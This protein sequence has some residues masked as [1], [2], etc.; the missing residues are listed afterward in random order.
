[1]AGAVTPAEEAAK[2]RL[3][4]ESSRLAA[5]EQRAIAQQTVLELYNKVETLTTDLAAKQGNWNTTEN[6][7]KLKFMELD[8]A[9]AQLQ[10][11]RVPMY[12][13]LMLAPC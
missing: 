3:T 8:G 1:M 10:V 2:L 11:W 12:S 4:L 5:V 6:N 9:N 13:S 7:L